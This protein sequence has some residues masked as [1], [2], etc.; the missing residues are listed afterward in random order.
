MEEE[1]NE[2]DEL[3]LKA[4]DH[5]NAYQNWVMKAYNRRIKSK[6]FT[7]RDFKASHAN[8]A[9]KLIIWKRSPN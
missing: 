8:W 6:S 4:L 3:R 7:I 5:L 1:F 9:K 2:L